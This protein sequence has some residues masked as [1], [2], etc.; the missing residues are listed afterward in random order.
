VRKREASA[1][2]RIAQDAAVNLQLIT[3][4]DL[5]RFAEVAGLPVVDSAI[6]DNIADQMNAA[7]EGYAAGHPPLGSNYT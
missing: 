6:L 3:P 5:T 4:A 2:P 7:F 1:P